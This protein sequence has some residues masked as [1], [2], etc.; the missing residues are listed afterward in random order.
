MNTNSTTGATIIGESDALGTTVEHL[1]LD[2]STIRSIG[3][4]TV[5]AAA[6]HQQGD[7]FFSIVPEG[8]QAKN[9]TAEIESAAL[10]PRRKSGTVHLADVTSFA[11]FVSQQGS[12]DNTYIYANPDT[13]TLVAI[14]N[15]HAIGE[16]A[17]GASLPGRRDY[18]AIYQAE[19]SREFAK[20][21]AFDGKQMSQEEFAVFLEDNIADIAPPADGSN[22]PSGDILL[23]VALTLQAKTEVDFKSH[24]RLDNGQSQLVYSEEVRATAG[25]DGTLDIPRSFAI[26]L[27][28]FK[29]GEGFRIN[30]RLK[31]RLGGGKLKF[32]YELDRPENAVEAAFQSY[33]DAASTSGFTVLTGKP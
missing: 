32:W 10:T 9:I 25:G 29:N 4:L 18:R 6:I 3:A 16:S 23:A 15:D 26:G 30:A 11:T 2:Q 12:P 17:G 33:I 20:W 21:L 27:R 13:R 24:K 1:H 19:Y 28:L 5:A 14:L 31:Y 7:A 22:E 8:Y